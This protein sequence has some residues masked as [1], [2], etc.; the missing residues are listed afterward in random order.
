MSQNSPRGSG[1]RHRS[2]TEPAIPSHRSPQRC[3][4]LRSRLRCRD[5]F[6]CTTL[7][8]TIL[9]PPPARERGP[10]F[11]KNEGGEKQACAPKAGRRQ[12]R[13]LVFSLKLLHE[14]EKSRT[15]LFPPVFFFLQVKEGACSTFSLP[16]QQGKG[17]AKLTMASSNWEARCGYCFQ[18]AT[19]I[20]QRRFLSY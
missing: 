17:G 4:L 9:V 11:E 6:V 7:T 5:R 8:A 14:N 12:A 16:M 13:G 18:E 20:N 19:W 2:S 10:V 15:F 3:A 1:V